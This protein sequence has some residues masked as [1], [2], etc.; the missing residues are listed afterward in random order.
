MKKEYL[1]MTLN[2]PGIGGIERSFEILEKYL[3]M[4]ECK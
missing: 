1:L 3:L 2:Y 4:N